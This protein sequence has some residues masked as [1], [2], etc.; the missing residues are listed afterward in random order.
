MQDVTGD[1][2]REGATEQPGRKEGEGGPWRGP[3]VCDVRVLTPLVCEPSGLTL[4]VPESTVPVCRVSR[5]RSPCPQ[6]GAHLRYEGHSQ[7][8]AEEP[9]SPRSQRASKGCEL[10]RYQAPRFP[11]TPSSGGAST[12]P[13][14]TLAPPAFYQHD[15]PSFLP[16]WK[17]LCHVQHC[18]S[19]INMGS[20]QEF[21]YVVKPQ[22]GLASAKARPLARAAGDTMW[23]PE[24]WCFSGAALWMRSET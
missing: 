2:W 23:G 5:G 10:L 21:D 24:H 9:H 12:P 3:Q 8:G 15:F 1:R 16:V 22:R 20:C 6:A 18:H 11:L 13:P 4:T 19:R 17:R 14:C 7:G